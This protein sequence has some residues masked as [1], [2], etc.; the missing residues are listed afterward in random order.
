[1]VPQKNKG[2]GGRYGEMLLG[3]KQDLV[4]M[5]EEKKKLGPCVKGRRGVGNHHGV[6][7]GKGRRNGCERRT[8]EGER[9]RC[10]GR[11]MPV[12]KM[13][14]PI[15]LPGNRQM[16]LVKRQGAKGRA[17]QNTGG[18]AVPPSSP[19]SA[20]PPGARGRPRCC[21]L[22]SEPLGEGG[23]GGGCIPGSPEV[24]FIDKRPLEWRAG[25]TMPAL[26]PGQLG[27]CKARGRQRRPRGKPS[28][29]VAFATVFA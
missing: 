19:L 16:V 8:G 13:N 23:R 3:V 9:C 11:M 20:P 26:S 7:V 1:M 14:S 6:L 5:E 17:R 10:W 22:H 21:R 18:L 29:R 4:L 15:A 24:N 25:G 2:E 27:L 28:R 12:L